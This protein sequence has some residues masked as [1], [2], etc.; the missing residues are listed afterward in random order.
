MDTSSS[1]VKIGAMILNGG[2]AIDIRGI[3][4][5]ARTLFD[6]VSAIVE[7]VSE[8]SGDRAY[9][10]SVAARG[11]GGYAIGSVVTDA[12]PLELAKAIEAAAHAPRGAKRYTLD[13]FLSRPSSDDL[14]P[15]ADSLPPGKKTYPYQIFDDLV[16]WFKPVEEIK[17][18]PLVREAARMIVAIIFHQDGGRCHYIHA[19][20][21]VIGRGFSRRTF[22]RARRELLDRGVVIERN[23]YL[24]LSASEGA[25]RVAEEGEWA[26]NGGAMRL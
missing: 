8:A 18:T 3:E 16:G 17:G 14:L 23:A 19:R 4:I 24:T 20:D 5:A 7:A 9:T 22:Y 21:V 26:P 12:T 1:G 10:L 15:T 2:D 25:R 11:G 6:A 13:V